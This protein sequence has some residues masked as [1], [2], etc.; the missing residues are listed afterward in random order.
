MGT[1]ASRDNHPIRCLWFLPLFTNASCIMPGPGP[2]CT[3]R[4]AQDFQELKLLLRKARREK[5]PDHG[6]FR[7]SLSLPEGWH[8]C[9][10]LWRS[11][12]GREFILGSVLCRDGSFSFLGITFG[13]KTEPKEG[14]RTR[15]FPALC[16]RPPL[17]ED[18]R[19]PAW[20]FLCPGA[21]LLSLDVYWG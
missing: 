13:G 16:S 17:L 10:A 1:G 20:E 3:R 2:R 15:G 8:S 7:A 5:P 18:I 6:D 14:S 11:A 19:I 4:S 9:N 12:E 21:T